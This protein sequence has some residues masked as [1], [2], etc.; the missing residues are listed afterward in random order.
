MN[1]PTIAI[2]AGE[3]DTQ[4]SAQTEHDFSTW[5]IFCGLSFYWWRIPEEK[6]VPLPEVEGLMSCT[7]QGSKAFVASFPSNTPFFGPTLV[8]F[9]SLPR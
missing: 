4:I 8:F 1:P 5:N 7:D 2:V 6:F 9:T 3:S